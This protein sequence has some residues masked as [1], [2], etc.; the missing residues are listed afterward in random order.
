MRVY[1]G[2]PC[3]GLRGAVSAWSAASPGM[4]ILY[5]GQGFSTQKLGQSHLSCHLKW[6]VR[7]SSFFS[8]YLHVLFNLSWEELCFINIHV[9][10]AQRSERQSYQDSFTKYNVGKNIPIPSCFPHLPSVCKR[11]LHMLITCISFYLNFVA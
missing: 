9:C 2:F 8:S 5:K 3:C 1:T 6:N 4:A 10:K 7:I 11:Y